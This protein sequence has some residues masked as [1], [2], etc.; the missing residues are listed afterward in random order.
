LPTNTTRFFAL[1]GLY[2]RR[3]LAEA[4]D[5]ERLRRDAVRTR[6]P[7]PLAFG[8]RECLDLDRLRQAPTERLVELRENA[9]LFELRAP[10]TDGEH[11]GVDLAQGLRGQGDLHREPLSPGS[12][13]NRGPMLNLAT[14]IRAP[15][16]AELAR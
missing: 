8:R 1:A 3:L 14:A 9:A 15:I 13:P 6:E 11:V 5:D 2:G 10:H 12:V 16:D 7:K 4:E